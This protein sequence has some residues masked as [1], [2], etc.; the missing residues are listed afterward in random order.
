M[1][2]SREYCLSKLLTDRAFLH[3]LPIELGS[4]I[5]VGTLS[6]KLASCCSNVKKSLDLYFVK[7][8]VLFILM[9]SEDLVF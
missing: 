4:R 9:D 6:I 7:S 8:I 3:L 1:V 5:S 2:L